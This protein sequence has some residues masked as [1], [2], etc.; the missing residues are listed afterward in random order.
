MRKLRDVFYIN[1][2]PQN[3]E[4]VYYG[5]EFKEFIKFIPTELDN[6]LLLKSGYYG[7]EYSSKYNFET[8]KKEEMQEF[9]KENIDGYG[10]FCW[11]DFDS[12]DNVDSLKS[13][14]V[15]ELLYLGHMFSPVKSPF[16]EKLQN[17]YAYLAHDDGWF[18]RLYCRNFND[19]GEVIA[20]K[21]VSMTSTSK[22][23]KIYTMNDKLKSQLLSMAEDGLLIDFNNILRYERSIEIP[24]YKIGMF[25]NMDDM[26]NDLKRHIERAR[27][28]AKLVHKNKG[29]TIEYVQ[30][31]N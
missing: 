3:N 19:F 15:A 1:S 21:V 12:L 30:E 31:R 18:C 5:L 6:I 14:E 16:F 9:V 13:E 29:W 11:I 27:Y 25:I 8:I 4:L 26:Y 17:R 22:R 24:I 20:N 28:S 23:R 7:T 2:F 10:D